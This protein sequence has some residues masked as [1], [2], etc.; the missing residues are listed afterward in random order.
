L[1]SV[2]AYCKV[3]CDPVCPTN[4]TAMKIEKTQFF[5]GSNKNLLS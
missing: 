5:R 1:L 3:Y 2:L 4:K